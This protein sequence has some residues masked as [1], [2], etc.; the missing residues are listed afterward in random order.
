MIKH[1]LGQ[2][3]RER[4]RTM[5]LTQRDLASK[6]GVRASHIA[7]IEGGLRRPS[8]ALLKRLADTLALDHQRLLFLSHPE[9]R[10]LINVNP[11]SA[12]AENEAAPWRRFLTDRKL[13]SKY[14]I[15]RREIEALRCLSLLGYV[16]TQR[17]FIAILVLVRQSE[18]F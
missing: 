2:V 9:A 5:S 17:E 13:R 12:R 7:Y 3:I 11:S 16:L 10:S 6:V 1:T 15:T 8:L 4:R 14:C 18:E